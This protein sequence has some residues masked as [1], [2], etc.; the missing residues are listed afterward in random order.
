M[1]NHLP[2]SS[3]SGRWLGLVVVVGMFV[4]GAASFLPRQCLWLDEATQ[5]TGLR[6]G[7]AGVAR[8]LAGGGPNDTGQFRDR[9]PP[10]SYWLGWAWARAFGFDEASLRWFSVTCVAVA[11][12]LVFEAARLAFGTASAWVS[13]LLFALSPAVI[14][15]SVEIRAYPLFLLW[16]ALAFHGLVRLNLTPSDERRATYPALALALSAAVSTHFFGAVLAG[17]MLAALIILAGRGAGRFWPVVGV[18][19]VF[20]VSMAMLLPYIAV[21]FALYGHGVTGGVGYGPSLNGV[22]GLLVKLV[23]HVTLSV[24]RPVAVVAVTAA[25]VLIVLATGVARPSRRPGVA[26]ALTLGLGVLVVAAAKLVLSRF[27]A[28]SSNYNAWMRPGVCVLLSAGVAAPSRAA[29]RVAALASGLLLAAQASGVY[30]LAAHGDH[31]AHGPH[32]TVVELIRARDPREIAVVHDDPTHRFLLV[33]CP[34]R[35][36]LGPGLKHYE[37]VDAKDGSA[38]VRDYPTRRGV[39]P[40][41][42]LPH[43]YLVVVRSEVTNPTDLAAQVSGGD[44]DLGDGPLA[45]ALRASGD[46]RVVSERLAVAQVTAKIDLFERRRPLCQDAPRLAHPKPTAY[47]TPSEARTDWGRQVVPGRIVM[48]PGIRTGA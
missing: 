39:C 47:P 17:S 2:G 35:C 31:F 45:R 18:G 7:P 6:L 20:A 38:L 10:L 42:G 36:E 25:V 44:W 16:S 11:A 26:V 41:T 9:M 46:W 37:L 22:K 43:H 21:S 1:Q 23:S 15:L 32:R 4:V 19:G 12:A 24:H 33:Y 29:R 8:W 40:V 13:G 28:A 3:A 48:R 5:M 14:V 34:I 30:Q 27:D